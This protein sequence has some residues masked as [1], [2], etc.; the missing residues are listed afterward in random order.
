MTV[1]TL[2]ENLATLMPEV[3]LTVFICAVLILDMFLGKEASRRYC[4]WLGLCGTV[5]SFFVL[6]FHCPAC[7]ATDAPL[8][9]FHGFMLVDDLSH[10]LRLIILAGASLSLIFTLVSEQTGQWRHGEYVGLMLGA[11]LGAC[12]LASANNMIIFILA[13]ETLSMCSYVLAGYRKR[14]RAS[15]EASL[16]YLLYGAVA[17]GV[18]LFGFSYCYGITGTMDLSKLLPAMAETGAGGRMAGALALLLVLCGLGFKMA[19]APFQ[20]WCPDVYQGAPTPVTAFLAVVSKAA[21]FAALLRLLLPLY[22]HVDIP[23]SETELLRSFATDFSLTQLISEYRL[24]WLLGGLALVTMCFGNLAALGQRNVKRMLAYSSIAHAGYL[25]MAL[26]VFSPVALRAVIFYLVAYLLM[27]MGAFL[28]VILIENR[29]GGCDLE[30]FR[31]AKACSPWLLVAM[32]VFLISLTGLPPTVGFVGKVLLFEVVISQGLSLAGAAATHSLGVFL[33]VLAVVGVLNS[34]VSL[35]YYM[36]VIRAM[37]FEEDESATWTLSRGALAGPLAL[38]GLLI[39][40]LY[41]E[42][43]LRFASVVMHQAE[44]ILLTWM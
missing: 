39:V 5:L 22:M 25:L 18:M 32:F 24:T 42:P 33:L 9:T 14:D 30:H 6:F 21:G 23:A 27:N 36:Q 28:V 43:L 26:S 41:F 40:L 11:T 3:I 29:R 38:A 1:Y 15:A 34:A 2:F 35:Y 16:K 44:P 8:G 4:T 20:F 10:V 12:L 17:S 19:I 7:R 37:A 31:G 13:L